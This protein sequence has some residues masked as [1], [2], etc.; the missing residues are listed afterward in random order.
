MISF[1][2]FRVVRIE[3]W[4]EGCHFDFERTFQWHF[5]HFRWALKS[6]L[7]CNLGKA[8][9]LKPVSLGNERFGRPAPCDRWL[10]KS[11]EAMPEK[12]QSWAVGFEADMIGPFLWLTLKV[13]SSEGCHPIASV[14]DESSARHSAEFEFPSLCV[15]VCVRA[16][17]SDQVWWLTIKTETLIT[18]LQ[19]HI[20]RSRVPLKRPLLLFPPLSY[21]DWW[22]KEV[23]IKRGINNCT[24]SS[25]FKRCAGDLRARPPRSGRSSGFPAPWRPTAAAN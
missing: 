5:G 14:R 16:E 12:T 10:K 1:R 19:P 4:P 17:Q 20:S 25:A 23:E 2:W 3:K 9:L 15:C 7:T 22:A 8:H 13:N 18:R 11:E 21:W 6:E 24:P